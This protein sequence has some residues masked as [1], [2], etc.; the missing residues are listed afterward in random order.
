MEKTR[1]KKLGDVGERLAFAR[2]TELGYR[3]LDTNWRCQI[4]E[5][6]AVAWY[7]Q[8]L[9]FIEVRTRQ[10]AGAGTP[11]DS[12]TRTKL[13]RL[14]QLVAAYLAAHSN[15]CG[16]SGEW[17]SCRIDLVAVEFDRAGL[18]VRLEI[19]QNISEAG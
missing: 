12:L 4:G 13:Q 14:E 18:L 11:E 17:P 2:L 7:G 6:D 8:C 15:L 3:L 5:L 10:G 19:R 1:R 16:E 9:T